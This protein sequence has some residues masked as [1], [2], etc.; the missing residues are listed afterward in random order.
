M[1]PTLDPDDA[2]DELVPWWMDDAPHGRGI[3]PAFFLAC[4]VVGPALWVVSWVI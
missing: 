2:T 1:R 3:H 4:L